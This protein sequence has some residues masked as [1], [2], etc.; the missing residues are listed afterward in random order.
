MTSPAAHVAKTDTSPKSESALSNEPQYDYKKF[1]HER[2][3]RIERHCGLSVIQ[4]P[5][6]QVQMKKDE[7]ERKIKLAEVKKAQDAL[8][9]FETNTTY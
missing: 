7:E 1:F 3:C 6:V 4:L 2:L 9:T 8:D 5:E